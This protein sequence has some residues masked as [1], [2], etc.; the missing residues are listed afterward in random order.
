MEELLK[1]KK[2]QKKGP[3]ITWTDLKE[4]KPLFFY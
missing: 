2:G 4:K 3:T 1:F